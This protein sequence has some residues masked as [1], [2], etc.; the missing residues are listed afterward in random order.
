MFVMESYIEKQTCPASMS[1]VMDKYY[2][3]HANCSAYSVVQ[4]RSAVT[5]WKTLPNNIKGHEQLNTF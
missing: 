2:Y 1:Y 5:L 4:G 3:K